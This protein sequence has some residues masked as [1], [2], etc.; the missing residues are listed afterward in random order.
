MDSGSDPDRAALAAAVA[1]YFAALRH[2]DTG[3]LSALFLPEAHL[4]APGP[5][6]V[7]DLPL[8]AWLERVSARPD[9]GAAGLAT[10]GEILSLDLGA[11]DLGFAKVASTVPPA[12]YVDYLS[13]L[14]VDGR[15]RIIAKVYQRVG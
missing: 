7:A 2:S 8:A 15:W 9:F 1:E 10:P 12:R 14:R 5:E 11:P 13:F 6:G 3:R 4:Y